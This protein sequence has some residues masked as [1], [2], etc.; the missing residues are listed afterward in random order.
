MMFCQYFFISSSPFSPDTSYTCFWIYY[1]FLTSASLKN[2]FAWSFK[3]ILDYT[4][5]FKL[6]CFRY[7]RWIPSICHTDSQAH[8]FFFYYYY[9]YYYLKFKHFFFIYIFNL[10]LYVL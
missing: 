4:N 9:S 5:G 7:L 6:N 10:T 1:Q 2:P 8:H 3:G